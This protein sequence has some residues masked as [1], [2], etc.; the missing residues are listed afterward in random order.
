M[1]MATNIPASKV[2]ASTTAAGIAAALMTVFLWGA[3]ETWP[4]HPIPVVVQGALLVLVTA[5][6]TYLAG[7][8]TPPAERDQVVPKS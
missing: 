7:Y 2:Q 5:A 1:K 4:A 3:G 6:C 8:F